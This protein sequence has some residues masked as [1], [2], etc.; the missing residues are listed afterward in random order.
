MGN[1]TC[2][3]SDSLV[4][5][6][7]IP[8][9]KVGASSSPSTDLDVEVS[10]ADDQPNL[11]EKKD[12][13]DSNK[14]RFDLTGMADVKRSATDNVQP[15]RF[16]RKATRK[17]TDMLSSSQRKTKRSFTVVQPI[18]LTG[19]S[20]RVKLSKPLGGEESTK[21]GLD[22]DYAE[23]NPFIPIVDITEGL[24]SK[25]NE[26]NPK[27]P[28]RAGDTI[29]AVNGVVKDA[30]KMLMTLTTAGV[31]DILVARGEAETTGLEPVASGLLAGDAYISAQIEEQ[32]KSSQTQRH[33]TLNIVE[34]W[35]RNISS[36]GNDLEECRRKSGRKQSLTWSVRG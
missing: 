9:G 12:I 35:T 16:S 6:T 25:W 36:E 8:D 22:I 15:E 21:L 23:E 1:Y 24:A 29:V 19:G 28:L 13:S 33:A 17:S 7:G 4:T 27:L 2:C 18:G 31:L 11:K 3:T 20:Y 10:C 26:D 5:E 30:A 34:K 14:E 32:D